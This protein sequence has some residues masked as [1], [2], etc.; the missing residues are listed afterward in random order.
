MTKHSLKDPDHPIWQ[1]S[2]ELVKLIPTLGV[3]WFITS[4][5][6]SE[7]LVAETAVGTT[8]VVEIIRFILHKKKEDRNGKE[9]VTNGS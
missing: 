7:W 8:V 6:D 4:K 9:E 5:F 2:M 3:L 1:I